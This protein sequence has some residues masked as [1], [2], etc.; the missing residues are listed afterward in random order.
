MFKS[1]EHQYIDYTT[2]EKTTPSHVT[3]TIHKTKLYSGAS[4]ILVSIYYKTLVDCLLFKP[5]FNHVLLY[6][7][8]TVI[9]ELSDSSNEKSSIGHCEG[10]SNSDGIV[11]IPESAELTIPNIIIN[12]STSTTPSG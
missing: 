4:S 7:H 10:H 2:L 3:H 9:L 5:V 6:H 11:D 1:D 8:P 12:S